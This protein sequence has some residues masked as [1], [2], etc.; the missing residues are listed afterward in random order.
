MPRREQYPKVI[1]LRLRKTDFVKLNQLCK[2]TNRARADLLR[3]LIAR[4]EL[5][6]FPDVILRRTEP[7][8]RSS[9]QPRQ[10]QRQK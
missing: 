5:S 10:H 3:E 6:D 9:R 4:A 1:G 7:T 2:A 8:R